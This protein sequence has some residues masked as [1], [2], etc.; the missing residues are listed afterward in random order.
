MR[1][2]LTISAL[3]FAIV[4]LCCDVAFGQA[5]LPEAPS[6]TK[7]IDKSWILF[8]VAAGAD[9]GASI[10]DTHIT[11]VGLSAGHGCTERNGGDPMPSSAKLYS[12]NLGITGGLIGMGFVFKKLHIPIAPYAAMGM[13]TVKHIHGGYEWYSFKGGACL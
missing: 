8:G 9:I 7:H 1:F 2:K 6:H 10:F 12:K 3:V 13:D 4:A 11:Q 5:V